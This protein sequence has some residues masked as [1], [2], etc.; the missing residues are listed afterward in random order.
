FSIDGKYDAG[1]FTGSVMTGIYLHRPT[2]FAHRRRPHVR[3][4]GIAG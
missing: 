3:T 2:I 1:P 4:C